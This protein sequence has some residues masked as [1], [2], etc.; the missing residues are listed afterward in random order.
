M[1]RQEHKTLHGCKTFQKCRLSK[2][3]SFQK[4]WTLTLRIVGTENQAGKCNK[5]CKY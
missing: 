2:I 1:W 5:T 3:K 4:Y